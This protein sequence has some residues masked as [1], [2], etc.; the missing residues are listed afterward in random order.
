MKSVVHCSVK[1]VFKNLLENIVFWKGCS[2][3]FLS[4]DIQRK[5]IDNKYNNAHDNEN[6]LYNM[7]HEYEISNKCELVLDKK[8]DSSITAVFI[9]EQ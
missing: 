7:A 1:N 4:V 5:W 2:R 9:N 6:L 8:N 3:Q